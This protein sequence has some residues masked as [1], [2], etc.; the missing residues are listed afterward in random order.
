[1]LETLSQTASVDME[2]L[3]CDTSSVFLLLFALT[4]KMGM[5]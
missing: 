3:I 1:M 4:D 5:S 2:T